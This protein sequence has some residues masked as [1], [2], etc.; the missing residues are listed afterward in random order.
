MGGRSA[1]ELW[2]PAC[3]EVDHPNVCSIG[4]VGFSIRVVLHNDTIDRDDDVRV[5]VILLFE[6]RFNG[7]SFAPLAL[8]SSV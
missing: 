6:Q 7:K 5:G 8:F 1:L 2:L 4:D 3:N